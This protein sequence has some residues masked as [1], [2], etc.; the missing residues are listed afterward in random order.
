MNNQ[1][2]ATN[3][4]ATIALTRRLIDQGKEEIRDDLIRAVAQLQEGE[5]VEFEG[6]R[7]LTGLPGPQGE[8][9]ASGP[10]G[11]AGPLGPIGTR[12]SVGVKG[13]K[14]DQ[15]D[16]GPEGPQG[17]QGPK[18]EMPD[19]SQLIRD[20]E[21]RFEQLRISLT[22]RINR[23]FTLRGRGGGSAGG[24]SVNILENDDVTFRD[25][26]ELANNDILIF[27]GNGIDGKFD[28]MSLI[29]VINTVKDQLLLEIKRTRFVDVA[30]QITYIGESTPGTANS[31]AEWRIQ[32]INET[33]A[34]GDVQIQWANNSTEFIHS[35]NDRLSLT[36]G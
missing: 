28:K 24:G 6:K 7:G 9:G 16:Q 5:I 18:G 2:D 30:G 14:G 25:L 3:L 8:K 13:D 32:R 10:E 20:M 22:A 23:E 34:D 36:Y 35:W 1:L 21:F 31:T 15:G 33:A 29:T 27:K 12:G 26:S 19:V 17:D 4:A 11:P